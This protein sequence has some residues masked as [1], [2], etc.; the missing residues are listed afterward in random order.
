MGN[1]ISYNSVVS[2]RFIKP[3]V[4]P[5]VQH[6]M[7][8]V[9]PHLRRYPFLVTLLTKFRKSPLVHAMEPQV[10]V[11]VNQAC[12]FLVQ[13]LQIKEFAISIVRGVGDGANVP[14]GTRIL[15]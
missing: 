5:I 12:W 9:V 2:L 15:V 14:P 3:R 8:H 6:D 7:H 11:L 4:V 13:Y 1:M 10:A